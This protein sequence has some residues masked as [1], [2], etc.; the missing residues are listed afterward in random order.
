MTKVIK[1]C[2]AE[3]LGGNS[4]IPVII[5]I[6]DK[7]PKF[8]SA[9][10]FLAAA[11]SFYQDQAEQICKALHESLPQGTF[12]RL[13]IELARIKTTLYRGITND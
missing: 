10:V 7:L 2:M 11:D 13:W 4:P 12:D 8:Q 9:E 6:T 1:I 5:E 3:P